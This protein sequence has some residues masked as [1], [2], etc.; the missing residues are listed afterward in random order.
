M[1]KKL[2]G[3][4]AMM[5][6]VTIAGTS[7]L[8]GCGSKNE[9][10]SAKGKSKTLNIW[11]NMEAETDTLQKLADEYGKKSGY[12]IT[13]KHQ[14]P[15]VQKFAQAV[16]GKDGP[17]AVLGIPNDQLA[18]FVDAGLTAET[19]KDL[20]KDSDFSK[21]AVMATYVDGKRVAVPVSVETI[22]LYYNTDKVKELP[23]SWEELAKTSKDIGGIQ[24]DATSIYYDLGFLRASGGYIFKYKDGAYDV[25][26]I[27]LNTDGAADAY[28][29]IESLNKD[30]GYVSA[31]VTSDIAKSNFQNGETAYYIG[32][33]W[34]VSGF[35]SAGTKFAVAPMPKF[36]GKDF[37]TPVGTQIGFVS[38]KSENQ[39][40]A[41]K[42]M[43][44]VADNG[45]EDLYKAGSRIPAK[46]SEQEKDYVQ[47]TPATKAFIQQM[48][49][50]EP[51][52]TVSEM[53]QLWDIYS[54]NIKSMFTGDI[55][56]EA[57]GKNIKDQLEE[58]IKLMDSGK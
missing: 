51:M 8:T 12:K 56:P 17:D 36:N 54:N 10:A 4:A 28:K 53:G 42:F 20:Y 31:D 22:A 13:V 41:W 38:S 29:F 57:V 16:K 44:Y 27:G 43:M 2:L 25:K 32:G 18:N 50:G 24:F 9:T 58:A 11:T 30:Y 19:P 21:A 39:D 14:S 23:S 35:T 7:V 55:T 15:D 48:N 3:Q 46:L 45:A 37:V 40:A 5:L 33:P 49:N 47:N 52:P 34:D 1:K 26:D 6:A